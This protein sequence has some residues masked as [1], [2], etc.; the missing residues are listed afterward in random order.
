MNRYL[1]LIHFASRWSRE[2]DPAARGA[3]VLAAIRGVLDDCETVLT[4]DHAI[5]VC[6][7]SRKS[8]REVWAAL[9]L[10]VFRQDN[11]SVISLGRDIS[12]I[13]PGFA[14]WDARTRWLSKSDAD[15]P[16]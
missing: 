3:Q 8:A 14:D 11:L 6:G 15:P 1:V 4:E 5:G 12:T 16:R 13:H 9:Q 7:L 10:P 2:K